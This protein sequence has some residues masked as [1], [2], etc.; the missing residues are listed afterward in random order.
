M[1]TLLKLLVPV[2]SFLI[3]PVACVMDSSDEENDIDATSIVKVGDRIPA[4]TVEVVDHGQRSLF[5]S[6]QLKTET[7]IVFFH[8]T[9]PDCQRELPVI[10]AWY[11]RHRAG[12][13]CYVVAIARAEDEAAIAAFWQEHSLTIPYSPQPDRSI[14][15]LF[16]TQYIPRAYL[17]SSKGV[18][19]W[20]GIE[21]FDL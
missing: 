11:Q 3:L 5:S 14:Y 2:M 1:R 12:D 6:E 7:M 8:T 20:M 18:V 21:Q 17:C 19:T 13:S 4:F 10:D 15:H 16:A 9:C